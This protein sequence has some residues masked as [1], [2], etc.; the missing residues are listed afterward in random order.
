M[1]RTNSH[2]HQFIFD[3]DYSESKDYTKVKLRK[4]AN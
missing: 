2:L 3:D 4:I 1:G